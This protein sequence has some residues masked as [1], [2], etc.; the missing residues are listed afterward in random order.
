MASNKKSLELD[1]RIQAVVDEEFSDFEKYL[2]TPQDKALY[3]RKRKEYWG[4]ISAR[5]KEE[6]SDGRTDDTANG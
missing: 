5:L 4:K 2:P 3:K 1:A 6:S